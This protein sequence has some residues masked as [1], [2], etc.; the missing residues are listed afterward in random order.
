MRD[1]QRQKVYDSEG[2]TFGWADSKTA[3]GM[4]EID[5]F[6]RKITR[7]DWWEKNFGHGWNITVTSGRYGATSYGGRSGHISFGV[8]ARKKCYI[9]HELSHNICNA[10]YGRSNI[11]GHGWQFCATYLTLVR[12]Y[13]GVEE[14]DRL[15]AEFKKRGVRFREPR[16]RSMTPEQKEALPRAPGCR[17]RR[18][19]RHTGRLGRT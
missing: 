18:S 6:V 5:A 15:K 13:L 1:S 19:W 17:P 10:K 3:M 2:A 9:F 11:A 14:H 4:S 12:H 7:T 8:A 16:K